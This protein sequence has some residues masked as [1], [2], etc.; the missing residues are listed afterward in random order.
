MVSQTGIVFRDV[1]RAFAVSGRGG[2]EDIQYQTTAG[3]LFGDLRLV[4][5]AR[6]RVHGYAIGVPRVTQG[7]IA[8]QHRDDGGKVSGNDGLPKLLG[9][10]WIGF[11][12]GWRSA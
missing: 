8:I 10:Q 7:R 9:V 11:G 6:K 1:V 3:D 5:E 4:F 2:L 12:F